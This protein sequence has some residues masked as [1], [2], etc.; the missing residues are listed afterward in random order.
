MPVLST[1]HFGL[2]AA[3]T[4]GVFLV[5][6]IPLYALASVVGM[7]G[8]YLGDVVTGW[9]NP[10]A[11]HAMLQVRAGGLGWAPV[12]SSYCTVQHSMRSAVVACET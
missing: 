12:I 6:D 1:A 10:A 2:C 3:H 9:M 8:T 11:F 5:A 7:V 4:Q